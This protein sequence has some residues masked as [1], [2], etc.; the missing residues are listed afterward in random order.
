[1]YV[2]YFDRHV[3]I[4]HE[5]PSI[6]ILLC[7]EKKDTLAKLTLPKNSNIYT[8]EYSLYLPDTKLLQGRLNEWI[9]EFENE[10][11]ENV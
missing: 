7:K 11:E 10:A 1:M 6:G 5:K 8:S 4:P 2:S 9:N 3:K